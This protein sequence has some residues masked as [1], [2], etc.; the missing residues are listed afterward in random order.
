LN[1]L[2]IFGKAAVRAQGLSQANNPSW[3]CENIRGATLERAHKLTIWVQRQGLN[4]IPQSGTREKGVSGP[5]Y[6]PH[7]SVSRKH[8]TVALEAIILKSDTWGVVPC[9]GSKL[10]LFTSLAPRRE[11]AVVPEGMYIE[12]SSLNR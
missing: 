1:T 12:E 10:V 5:R 3:S 6:E 11:N 9:A 7:W 8:S 2:V 4:S